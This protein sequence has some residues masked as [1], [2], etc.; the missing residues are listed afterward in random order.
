M[1]TSTTVTS[2][3]LKTNL[4]EDKEDKVI[5]FLLV[6]LKVNLIHVCKATV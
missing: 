4:K 6:P 5:T 3:D 1:D 2:D